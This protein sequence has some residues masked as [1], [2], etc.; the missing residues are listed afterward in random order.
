M[1]KIIHKSRIWNHL[2]FI[3][4]LIF[5]FTLIA[6]KLT[7][8]PLPFFDWDESL[9]IQNGTEMIKNNYYLMPLWQGE[10]W[11]DKPPLIP[12]LYGL[13]SKIFFF[14]TPEVSTRLFSLTVASVVLSFLYAIYYRVTQKQ[15]IALGAVIITS[16]T[17]LFLQRTQTVNLDI[18]VLLS[19]TGYALFYKH[20][21]KSTAFLFIGIMSKSL[22]G[23]YPLGIM[24]LYFFY[25]RFITRKISMKEFIPEMNKIIRQGALMA[26]W[27]LLMLLIFKADFWRMHIIESH[28]KRV[29]ESIESHFGKRTYYIDLLV[30]QMGLATVI[31][32]IIGIISMV[33]LYWKK[34]IDEPKLLLA[35]FLLPWF[36]FLN[37]TKTKIFWYLLPALP[38]FAFLSVFVLVIFAKNKYIYFTLGIIIIGTFLYQGVFQKGYLQYKYSEFSDHYKMALFAKNK[39]DQLLILVSPQSRKTYKTLDDMNLTITTTAWWGEHP[40][41]VYYFGKY[42][43]FV[44]DLQ[45]FQQ[46]MPKIPASYCIVTSEEDIGIVDKKYSILNTFGAYSLFKNQSLN[47]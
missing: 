20:F 36:L 3:L 2:P 27:F 8:N 42:I 26:L 19:W 6:Y 45:E 29:T 28:F 47:Q 12:L 14:T 10:I 43:D 5:F 13:V 35:L 7:S 40:S 21:W 32:S 4:Y 30:E 38:Q 11:L 46:K 18:F 34:K 15:F 31:T 33:Y 16:F 44:F 41:M 17:P 25:M 24:T 22:L 23:F 39:C 9:Y 1:K 37:V